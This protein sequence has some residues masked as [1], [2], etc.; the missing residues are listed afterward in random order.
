MRQREPRAVQELPLEPEET[1]AAVFGVATDG[2][3]RCREVGPDL[4]GAAGLQPR[5]DKREAVEEAL[6]LEMRASGPGLRRPRRHAGAPAG[7]APD[8][9]IDRSS[10]CTEAT[11]D[12]GKILA[13]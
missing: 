7:V 10:P 1:A 9:R 6:D 3:A 5:P 2:V 4:M 8:R 13:L 11:L 12:Q